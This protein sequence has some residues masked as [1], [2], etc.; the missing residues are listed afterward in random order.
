M[1]KRV[2]SLLIVVTMILSSLPQQVFAEEICNHNWSSWYISE[3]PTCGEP[4]K[5]ERYCL[6]C[7][8]EEY[9]DIPATGEHEWDDWYTIK[10]AT[11]SKAGLKERECYICGETQTKETSKLKPYIKLSKKTVK[12]Q[13][14][15]SYTLKIGYAK[16]DSI[17]KCHSSNTKV[18]TVSKKGK[19]KGVSVGTAKITVTLKSGKKATCKVT[20]SAKKETTV[21]WTPNG[22]VYHKTPNCPTLKRSRTICSGSLSNCPKP[23]ACKVCY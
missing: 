11:I 21:Y 22:E 6:N 10:S 19:V 2:L 4:G 14:T 15:K 13:A 8:E 20:V 5:Q 17:K 1:K 3:E 23:R 18:A 12:I 7:Y 9:A 16:G